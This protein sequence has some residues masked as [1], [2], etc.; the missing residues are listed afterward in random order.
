MKMRR[1]GYSA[2]CS[3]IVNT[4]LAKGLQ[5]REGIDA[6][7]EVLQMKKQC[8]SALLTLCLTLALL[9]AVT[10]SAQAANSYSTQVIVNGETLGGVNNFSYLLND[11][12]R[13]HSGILGD[14]AVA[15]FDKTTGELT[16]QG[17][18]FGEIMETDSY[19]TPER[20]HYRDLTIK[21]VGDNTV[22]GE[23]AINNQGG[24][25]LIIT[26]DAPAT[27]TINAKS[28]YDRSVVGIVTDF[29]DTSGGTSNVTITGNANVHVNASTGNDTAAGIRTHGSV[30]ILGNASFSAVCTSKGTGYLSTVG[31]YSTRLATIN[32]TGNVTLDCSDPGNVNGRLFATLS[33]APA[34][35]RAGTLT[36]KWN[37]KVSIGY[38]F[39]YNTSK[40]IVTSDFAA[41]TKTYTYA[42]EALPVD[43]LAG[44]ERVTLMQPTPEPGYQFRYTTSSSPVADHMFAYGT[45]YF[46]APFSAPVVFADLT[47]GTP[48]YVQVYKIST[49]ENNSCVSFGQAYAI[50]AAGPPA[51]PTNLTAVASSTRADLSWKAPD[52]NG[53]SPI[54]G[55]E[56]RR[57]SSE[58]GTVDWVPTGSTATTHSVSGLTNNTMYIF[59]VRAVTA[60]G[61]GALSNASAAIPDAA[62]TTELSF[63]ATAK[64]GVTGKANT[65]AIYLNFPIGAP[66]GLK[67]DHITLYDNGGSAVKGSSL[68]FVNANRW[69]LAVEVLRPGYI[70]VGIDNFDGYYLTGTE[71]VWVDKVTTQFSTVALTVTIPVDG[72]T[73]DS[74]GVSVATADVDKYTATILNWF[75]KKSGQVMTASDPFVAGETYMVD[76]QFSP[77]SGYEPAPSVTTTIN[78][79]PPYMQLTSSQFYQTFTAIPAGKTPVS[80]TAA[81]LGG[82][83]GTAYST[84]ISLSFGT[85]VYGLTADDITIRAG[86]GDVLAGVL[87]GEG[88]SWIIALDSVVKEGDVYVSVASFVDYGVTTAEQTVAVYKNTAPPTVISA[89][90]LTVSP[91]ELGTNPDTNTATVTI[92]GDGDKYLAAGLS[93]RIGD[94]PMSL[95]DTFVAGEYYKAYVR[96]LPKSGYAFPAGTVPLPVTF[97]GLAGVDSSHSETEA[98]VFST[99]VQAIP[100]STIPVSF[101][102]EQ[103]DGIEGAAYTSGI[104]LTFDKPVS[105]LKATDITLYG[106]VDAVRTGA[107]IGSDGG[108]VWTLTLDSVEWQTTLYVY[109]ASFGSYG[110]TSVE[111]PVTVYVG[112]STT[113]SA[114]AITITP[115]VGGA[116]PDYAVIVN[117]AHASQYTAAVANWYNMI[118]ESMKP[119]DTFEAGQSYYARIELQRKSGYAFGYGTP[120]MVQGLSDAYYSYYAA[121]KAFLTSAN[122][123]AT[124]VTVPDITAPILS[125]GTTSGLS[126]TG[127]TLRFTSDEVG[128]YYFVVYPE[129]ESAPSI[130]TLKAQGTSYPKGIGV[131]IASENTAVMSGLSAATNYK[132]YVVVTDAAGNNSAVMTVPFSTPPTPV[133]VSVSGEVRSYN[134]KNAV[135]IELR[136]SGVMKF[137]TTIA[138]G[139]GTGQVTQAFSI[140]DVEDGTYD[141]VV[142]KA[143]HLSY[144]ITGVVVSGSDLDL[145][146]MTGKAYSTITLLAGD[147][148]GDGYINVGDVTILT[149][150]ANWNKAT[151]AAAN[152]AA[153]IN[154]DGYINVGDI[155]II[156]AA[157]NW[158]K[159]N[160]VVEA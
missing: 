68:T 48:L 50:P 128:T 59:N 154:G 102:A 98:W 8:I 95:T 120:A 44:N 24:G 109:V 110:V 19:W 104:K 49:H 101:T 72:A 42:D 92:L 155:T 26:A 138:A 66:A 30:N 152:Q 144:T 139:S 158:N 20:D 70:N 122:L 124:E 87:T 126:A 149:A 76:I 130:T 117:P 85:H 34:L 11:G 96:L 79:L 108:S 46:G 2:A 52:D 1:C 28:I 153:D 121:S 25:D 103:M 135:T 32:T 6:K 148:N 90:N 111:Q 137:S 77:K 7:M 78:G 125:E 150:A 123:T 55:Y 81:Q 41:C 94:N 140:P 151:S 22:T 65:T 60:S 10:T 45:G 100:P 69:E 56:V 80:F 127:G 159:G 73:P 53:G 3:E 21:L 5:I 89:V 51:A 107:L 131:A 27:L 106:D 33:E 142:T 97:N 13:A 114:V 58:E 15:Y 17:Y 63:Y 23:H 82:T 146:S 84:G 88:T 145:T 35:I 83:S 143:G 160:V 47:N 136:Q 4:T 12:T 116:Y 16:L 18:H 93:W 112:T 64:D 141:L 31:I 67:L 105:G 119:T 71:Q 75:N 62:A 29:G 147:V 40:F 43:L 157:S 38:Y 91:P 115:P 37:S 132:A 129:I 118:G 39:V 99:Y 57:T 156:T 54:T 134:P 113:I 74:Y 9:P 36:Q 14:T 133:G 61:A 86:S